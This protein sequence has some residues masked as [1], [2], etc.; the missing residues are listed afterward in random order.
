MLKSGPMSEP[1]PPPTQCKVMKA[2]AISK[3][4]EEEVT[5]GVK[6]LAKPPLLVGLLATR[7]APAKAY[8]DWTGKTCKEL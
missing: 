7:D 2:S 1:A 8:A 6:S 3:P 4:L 5:V